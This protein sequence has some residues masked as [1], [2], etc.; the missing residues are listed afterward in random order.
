MPR[1]AVVLCLAGL[2]ASA[3]PAEPDPAE[4][5]SKLRRLS[6]SDHADLA[7]WAV[8]KGLLAEANTHFSLAIRLDP[9]CR[10]ARMR[11]GHRRGKD[12]RWAPG[13][14]GDWTSPPAAREAAGA[15]FARRED[16]LFRGEATAYEALGL[17]LLDGS[18]EVARRLLLRALLLDPRREK[19][20]RG[21]SLAN[22]GEGFGWPEEAAALAAAPPVTETGTPF[23]GPLLG[24]ETILRSCGPVTV[25]TAA[26]PDAAGRLAKLV[27]DAEAFTA[28]RFGLAPA[29]DGWVTA[30]VAP[31]YAQF[32]SFVSKCGAFDE[33]M[34]AGVKAVGTARAFSPRHFLATSFDPAEGF[35]RAAEIFVHLAAENRLWET[36]PPHLPDWLFEAA[37]LD[38]CVTLLGK[39]GYPCVVLEE[40]SGPRMKDA[41]GDPAAFGR[42]TL[43]DSLD[44]K[45]PRLPGLMR[46]ELPALE[47]GDLVFAHTLYR[48]LA[49]S[50]RE[51]ML[52]FL[53]STE[54]ERE[55]ACKSAFGKE[56]GELE[57]EFLSLLAGE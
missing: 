9:E 57:E 29:R 42:R 10:A 28:R 56:S 13:A 1:I 55:A 22:A 39:P 31:N 8:G 2:V 35:D 54:A 16:D 32:V 11:L 47:V 45:G 40:S 37:G 52:D 48:W 6:A 24:I 26:D 17:E 41:F 25:E 20:A 14:P 49:F 50:R 12:G 30:C 21:L 7:V 51:K 46:A 36:D 5:V 44:R 23:L 38:A 19:A 33:A 15:D 3:A 18:K 34:L 27:R 4:R 53:R 43:I